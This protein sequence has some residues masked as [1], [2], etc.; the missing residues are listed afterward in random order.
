MKLKC[1]SAFGLVLME[2]SIPTSDVGLFVIFRI[3]KGFL[4]LLNSTVVFDVSSQLMLSK[5][6]ERK[7]V[8]LR[9][10]LRCFTWSDILASSSTS[11]GLLKKKSENKYRLSNHIFKQ[12][13][14]TIVLI[15][16]KI[17]KIAA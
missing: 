5:M 2:S 1:V 4:S 3:E 10:V 17:D 11:R 16:L 13:Y 15:I 8:L 6:F 9:F 14:N 7:F 12:L